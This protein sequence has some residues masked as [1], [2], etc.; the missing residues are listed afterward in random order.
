MARQPRLAVAGG[1]HHVALR[2]HDKTVVLVDDA[3]RSTFTTLLRESSRRLAVAL[4]AYA[5][6]DTEIHLLATPAQAQALGRLMQSIGR[7][8]V[9]TFNRRHGRRGALWDGRFRCSVLQ[10]ET[11]LL[12]ATVLIES[13]PVERDLVARA[14]DWAWSSAAH[15]LGLVRDHLITEHPGYWVIGNTPFERESAHANLL[16]VGVSTA[17]REALIQALQRGHAVGNADFVAS[18]AERSG[19]PVAPRRRGRPRRA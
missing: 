3:D 18:L 19:R 16:A 2:G 4:H 11:A 6:L 10:A 7:S 17:R 1:L 13:L 8:Y 12:D 14:G 5:L 15:H 9:S